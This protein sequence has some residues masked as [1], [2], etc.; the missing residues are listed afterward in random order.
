MAT[1]PSVLLFVYGTL[2]TVARHPMGDLLREKARPAG[3]GSI[4]A[5]LYVIQDPDDPRNAY[6]GAKPSG[7]PRDRVHGALYEI[8][9]D[10]EAVLAELDRYEACTPDWPEPHEFLRRRVPVRREDGSTCHA[11]CYLYTW[12]VSDARPIATGRY[13]IYSPDVR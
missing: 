7:D 11:V 4:Q 8:V 1:Q 9:S 3:L 5:R 13:D 2:L 6:P 10:V 12:D